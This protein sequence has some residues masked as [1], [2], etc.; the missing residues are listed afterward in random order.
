MERRNFCTERSN[1]CVE[2]SDYDN[3]ANWLLLGA[4]WPWGELTECPL[5]GPHAVRTANIHC[6]LRFEAFTIL[7]R[8]IYILI[9]GFGLRTPT[10]IHVLLYISLLGSHALRTKNIHGVLRSGAFTFSERRTCV[11]LSVF[12]S[13]AIHGSYEFDRI[14]YHQYVNIYAVHQLYDSWT[15]VSRPV[16][17]VSSHSR[18]VSVRQYWTR[19]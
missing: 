3:G 16:W 4:K 14:A 19:M 11:A 1:F 6:V 8:R 10:S 13:R 9:S 2:R 15:I 5:L 12:V 18:I 17:V 7:E